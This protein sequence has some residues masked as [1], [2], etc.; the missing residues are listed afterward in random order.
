MSK[1]FLIAGS[2]SGMLSVMIGAFGAHALKS[3]LEANQRLETFETAV[4]AAR[5]VVTKSSVTVVVPAVTEAVAHG[6]CALMSRPVESSMRVHKRR[7][8]GA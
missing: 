3:T 6:A 1:I 2:L 7:Q 5:A 4:A 8:L